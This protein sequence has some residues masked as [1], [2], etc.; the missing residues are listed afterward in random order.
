MVLQINNRWNA[1]ATTKGKIPR[2]RDF[3]QGITKGKGDQAGAQAIRELCRKD[4]FYLCYEVLGYRDLVEPLHDDLCDFIETCEKT[5]KTNIILIP[6]GHFKST[7]ATVGRCIQWMIRDQNT[8]IGLGSADLKS[9]KKFLREI[10][11]QLEQNTRLKA[12]FPDCF[13]N[14][15]RR[16]A[17][18]W[19]EEEI[20]IK[21]D[22]SKPNPKE[23][24]VKVFGLEDGL[25]T[26]DHYYHMVIDDAINEDNVRTT[27]RLAKVD[28][29]SRYLRPLLMTPDQPINWVGTRY[30]IFDIYQRLTDN[31]DNAVYL[32]QA[33]E[34][35]E[36]IFPERFSQKTLEATRIELG[37][38][39]FSCQYMLTPTDPADKK[40]KRDW[41]KWYTKEISKTYGHVFFLVVDPASRMRKSSDFTAMLVFGLDHDWNFYLVDGVHDK[42]NPAQRIDAVFR[43]TQKWGIGT[44]GYETI[45]FQETD[46]FYITQRQTKD[47]HYFEVVEIT[48][49]KTRKDERIM[50]LQPIME[51]GKFH[52]PA[53]PIL[54]QRMWESPDDGKG[55]TVDIVQE[56]LSE[57]DFFPN[58]AHDDLLDAAQMARHIVAAGHI[59]VSKVFFSE[60]VDYGHYNMYK[61]DDNEVSEWIA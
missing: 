2:F 30:H 4:L 17:T 19:T 59:P 20:I 1:R 48:S 5:Q 49:H 11:G 12:L 10:R 44:V 54:Y 28:Q 32:R 25:P 61:R 14:D 46:K 36:P 42:L 8:S 57:Y 16:E 3:V 13:Y 60:S 9:S 31:P 15:P 56:F 52:L 47:N 6:R 37:S 53:E 23:G 21:R 24:T 50:G 55:V 29:Q 34:G 26:G 41:L 58:S 39:I 40:F 51:S 7:I 43:L 45:G 22:T 38:Y 35:M 27:E 18:K 33:I